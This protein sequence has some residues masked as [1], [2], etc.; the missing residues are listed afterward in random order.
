MQNL[1]PADLTSQV[2]S[3]RGEEL[4][5]D[6]IR[7]IDTLQFLPF[8]IFSNPFNTDDHLHYRRYME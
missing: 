8:Q 6:F 4:D 2:S 7:A 3:S 1:K 5:S